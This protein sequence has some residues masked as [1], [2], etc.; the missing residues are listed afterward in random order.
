MHLQYF[1]FFRQLLSLLLLFLLS[2]MYSAV[3]TEAVNTFQQQQQRKESASL[4][5]NQYNDERNRSQTASQRNVDDLENKEKAVG[6]SEEK[7]VT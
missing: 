6:R 5:L 3:T 7:S 4:Q 2:I 1:L